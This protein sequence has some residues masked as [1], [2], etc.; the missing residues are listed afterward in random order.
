MNECGPKLE[1]GQTRPSAAPPGS[2][3]RSRRGGQTRHFVR[4]FS[5]GFFFQRENGDRCQGRQGHSPFRLLKGG[6]RRRPPPPQ[7]QRTHARRRRQG[8][9]PPPPPPP[10]PPRPS[11]PARRHRFQDVNL[12]VCDLLRALGQCSDNRCPPESAQEPC[13][14]PWPRRA[15]AAEPEVLLKEEAGCLSGGHVQGEA[16]DPGRGGARV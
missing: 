3:V 10:P 4:I 11:S 2:F 1:T 14:L 6:R 9:P 12:H 16:G 15:A 13:E 8:K 5:A 7:T